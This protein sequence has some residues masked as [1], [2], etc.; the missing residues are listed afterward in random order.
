MRVLH[1]IPSLAIQDGGPPRAMAAIA[2]ALHR[3]PVD[4]TIL[5]TS[6]DNGEDRDAVRIIEPVEVVS[7]RR[8]VRA[9]R[10]GGRRSRGCRKMWNDST[11]CTFTRSFPFSARLPH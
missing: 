5:T 10:L 8:N 1:V 9:T 7:V 6:A 11:L 4:V 3:V 2:K